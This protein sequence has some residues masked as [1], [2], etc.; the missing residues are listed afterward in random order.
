[1]YIYYILYYIYI[2]IY[3]YIYIVIF[4]VIRNNK[5][6]DYVYHIIVS[7]VVVLVALIMALSHFQRLTCNQGQLYILKSSL[8]QLQ[9]LNTGWE[10]VASNTNLIIVANQPILPTICINCSECHKD[11]QNDSPYLIPVI[12]VLLLT[13]LN[14]RKLLVGW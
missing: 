2:Y 7:Y 6:T 5:A 12:H 8:D 14:N 3:V 10:V 11:V 4:N 9:L 1:M 13:A